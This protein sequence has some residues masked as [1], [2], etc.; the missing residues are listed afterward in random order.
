MPSSELRAS[1]AG[2]RR[3][4]SGRVRCVFTTR[5]LGDMR[6]ARQRREALAQAGAPEPDARLLRQVHGKGLVVLQGAQ[7]DNA[8][9]DVG[10]G[11]VHPRADGWL[12]DRPGAAVGVV[13]A[14]CLPVWVWERSGRAAGVFHAGWRGLEA[15]ILGRAVEEFARSFGIRPGDLEASVGPHAGACCYRVGPEVA[16][17][18]RRDSLRLSGGET[19]LDL[20]AEARAQLAAAGLGSVAVSPDCT[21]CGAGRYFS[22]RREG[23]RGPLCGQMLACLWLEA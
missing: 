4:E 18:F 20:G 11:G 17:R 13:V 19:F 22:W 2:L 15:G 3:L 6:C 5:A 8:S 10:L 7:T 21:I 16:Q 14:D 23:G 9:P 1:A 12:T